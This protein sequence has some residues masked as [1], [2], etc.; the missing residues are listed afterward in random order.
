MKKVFLMK[1]IF[2]NI[3]VCSLLNILGWWVVDL[4]IFVIK[5]F[6]LIEIFIMVKLSVK[7][8]KF[9]IEFF[10]KKYLFCY[11]IFIFCVC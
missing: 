6:L 11:F 5:I 4:V 10:F 3:N 1:V 8:V 2:V 7:I 9:I